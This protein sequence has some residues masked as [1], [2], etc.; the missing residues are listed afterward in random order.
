MTIT[1]YDA[2]T[3][4]NIPHDAPAVAGYVDGFINYGDMVR[5][6]PNAKHI[7][8]SIHGNPADILDVE[9]GAATPGMVIPWID[10][11]F[12]EGADRPGVYATLSSWN[13]GIWH[14]L[15]PYGSKV[16][17]WV[18]DWTFREEILAGYDAQQWTGGQRAPYDISACLDSFFDGPPPPPP[19]PYHYNWFYTGPFPSK[20]GNLNERQI[21]QQYDGA[22][23]HP[24]KYAIYLKFTL[25]PR[26][27]FL[28]DRIASEAIYSDVAKKIKRKTPE[29]G[30]FNRGWRYQGLIHRSEGNQVVK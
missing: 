30:V 21:V 14:A 12:K 6:F 15:E 26:L 16:R 1:M 28:A 19:D 8:I 24:V 17:R 4:G 29:W 27:K 13:G 11:R 25:E 7:S 22:R 9:S 5:S 2:V 23:M 10:A 3:V 18:A 20:W